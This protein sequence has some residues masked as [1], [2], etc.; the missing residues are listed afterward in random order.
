ML[1]GLVFISNCQSQEAS[2]STESE[3]YVN[4]ILGK[5]SWLGRKL[6]NTSFFREKV[7]IYHSHQPAEFQQ[8]GDDRVYDLKMDND[9]VTTI[10]EDTKKGTIRKVSLRGY[11][12]D[13]YAVVAFASILC[14]GHAGL[15]TA[16][17]EGKFFIPLKPGSRFDN[18]VVLITAS[19]GTWNQRA[20]W[21][22]TA[23]V[24]DKPLPSQIISSDESHP[25]VK[26]TKP[27]QGQSAIEAK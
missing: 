7:G 9:G 3:E 1:S 6:T 24:F 5:A 15:P 2:S 23:E 10:W 12:P 22:L 11:F 26:S 14:E 18:S 21:S 8:I 13:I 16:A 25:E 4:E 17:T 19:G 27:P 20:A